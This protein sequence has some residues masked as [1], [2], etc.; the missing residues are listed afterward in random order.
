MTLCTEIRRE[1]KAIMIRGFVINTGGA[2]STEVVRLMNYGVDGLDVVDNA[3]DVKGRF[4][5]VGGRLGAGDKLVVC[6]LKNVCGTVEGLFEVLLM[7]ARRRFSLVSLE[8]EW[9]E[10]VGA[11]LCHDGGEALLSCIHHQVLPM[12]G[13]MEGERRGGGLERKNV[14]TEERE[15]QPAEQKTAIRGGRP[16]GSIKMTAEKLDLAV[17][18]YCQGD[19]TVRDICDIVRCNERSMYRYLKLRGVAGMRKIN[20]GETGKAA[21]QRGQER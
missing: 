15:K 13:N 4:L 7:W 21:E 19:F 1:K 18:M 6:S 5:A 3:G 10:G 14:L 2:G 8:E 17:R 12:M 11:I 16:K 20:G 9:L